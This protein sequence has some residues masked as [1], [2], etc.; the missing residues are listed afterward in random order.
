MN[1]TLRRGF[2]I[3]IDTTQTPKEQIIEERDPLQL[4]VPDY[5]L[6]D[7]IDS[8]IQAADDFWESS[9]DQGGMN[10][11]ERRERLGD[12][13]LGKQIDKADLHP[14]QRPYM[15]NILWE[16]YVR[17]R[18]ILMSRMPDLNITRGKAGS[19]ENAKLITQLIDTDVKKE[20]F[21]E[22][23]GMAALHRPFKFYGVLKAVWSKEK[24]DYEF[25]SINPE[26]IILDNSVT[27]QTKARFIGEKV[28]MTVEDMI[29]RF[30]KKKDDILEYLGAT[31]GWQEGDDKRR[32]KLATTVSVTEVW[33]K[34]YL[35]VTDET[36]GLK[37]FE[38][39]VGV[40][41]KYKD[42]ILHKMKH[43]YWDWKGKNE[44]FTL[45]EGEKKTLSE[46]D[47][48][49]ILFGDENR[50][51]VYTDTTFFNYLDR[52]EFPYYIMTLN[53]G[54]EH[55]IDVSSSYEQILHFQDDINRTGIQINEMNSRSVG[56]EVYSVDAFEN[57][58]DIENIDPRDVSQIIKVRG[59]DIRKVHAHIDFPAAPSQLYNSK[60]EARSIGF[61]ML[62][63]NDTTRGVRSGGDE[64]LGGKQMMRE[65][66][67][68]VLD[69]EVSR[70]INPAAQWMG[71]WI[72]QFIKRYYTT[73][74]Y[75]KLLG[76]DGVKLE[77]AI[78]QDLVDD[79]MEIEVSASSV[80]KMNRKRQA[81]TNAEAGYSDP[82]TYFKDTEQPDPEERAK[83]VML[84]KTSPELYMKTY[85]PEQNN[86][87]QMSDQLQGMP[88][89]QQMDAVGAAQP[90][91]P[92]MPPQ[93][94]P[95]APV[96]SPQ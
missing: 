31:A 30:P 59:E 70:T 76:E 6:A 77:Q 74:K 36:T 67:F 62:A 12:Y 90:P 25:R 32:S 89:A 71:R 63:L 23:I 47:I 51:D 60:S 69:Y 40:V 75:K 48:K 91:Q 8:R 15:E 64:T 14:S 66:D 57:E 19:E 95:Q 27:D 50:E 18:S 56:K 43:P 26:N 44:Y 1:A 96:Q 39:I 79:G 72:M 41:W 34:E 73:P 58:E 20:E 11:S 22:A 84:F 65:Q 78:S 46:D 87:Q 61:E 82:L 35:P 42:L 92:P 28:V 49:A 21:A 33:F 37:K 55:Q 52:P 9:I 10:L 83:K 88:P 38:T 54:G 24:N 45:E 80:D 2:F 53:K 81:V 16:A 7:V 93:G 13:L 85:L 5:I 17:N 68:G 86:A 29:M 94:A 4:N 3:M